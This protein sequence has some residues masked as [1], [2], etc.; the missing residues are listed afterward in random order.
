MVIVMMVA[1]VL[2]FSVMSLD[3]IVVIVEVVFPMIQTDTVI[4]GM[5]MVIP[6]KIIR[7]LLRQVLTYVI[8]PMLPLYLLR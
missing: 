7:Y 6:M 8:Y 2:F 1:M 3:G 4:A 5:K